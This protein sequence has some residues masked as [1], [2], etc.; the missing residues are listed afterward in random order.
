MNFL[1]LILLLFWKSISLRL[2]VRPSSCRFGCLRRCWFASILM[3]TLSSLPLGRANKQYSNIFV[4][5]KKQA[6]FKL[7]TKRNSIKK[8]DKTKLNGTHSRSQN[9]T[10][11]QTS[12]QL[13]CNNTSPSCR[14]QMVEC[15][16]FDLHEIQQ[17]LRNVV[18]TIE[19][20][21]PCRY[22]HKIA[23]IQIT[24]LYYIKLSI[25]L[26]LSISPTHIRTRFHNFLHVDETWYPRPLIPVVNME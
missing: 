20:T 19:N 2:S 9:V 16:S 14:R 7:I 26:C 22:V 12:K 10:K 6:N 23:Q 24:N 18:Y 17:T 21:I 4:D 13:F 5:I 11:E 25:R 8:S 1:S 3:S 15:S